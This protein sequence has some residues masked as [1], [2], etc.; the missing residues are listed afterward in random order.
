MKFPRVSLCLILSTSAF[1]QDFRPES[2]FETIPAADS[3]VQE[4]R[5]ANSCWVVGDT[6]AN[7]SVPGS[8]RTYDEV[9]QT[10]AHEIGHVLVDYGHPDDGGGHAPLP[11]TDHRE[12]LMHSG[13]GL[14]GP[15][16]IGIR[17]QQARGHRLVKQEWDEAEQW[18]KT[19]PNGDH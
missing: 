6:L 4:C 17:L 7:P 12:R 1:S 16:I 13:S 10:V 18:L 14:G 11:R 9:L 3:S 8:G 2:H 15:I 5:I 19:R